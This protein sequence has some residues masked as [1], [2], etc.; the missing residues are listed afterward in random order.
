MVTSGILLTEISFDMNNERG[1]ILLALRMGMLL[2]YFQRELGKMAKA[3]GGK[4][5]ADVKLWYVQRGKNKGT[6]L[7]KHIHIDNPDKNL[8]K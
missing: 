5:G 2:L 8:K 1:Y 6:E 4:W 3:M 7:Q